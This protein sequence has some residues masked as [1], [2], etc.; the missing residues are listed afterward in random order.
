MPPEEPLTVL[1]GD[2]Q[3]SAFSPT[4]I[5]RKSQFSKMGYTDKLTDSPITAR[6]KHLYNRAWYIENQKLMKGEKANHP[7][8]DATNAMHERSQIGGIDIMGDVIHCADSAGPHNAPA[9]GAVQEMKRWEASFES[10]LSSYKLLQTD[11][12]TDLLAQAPLMDSDADLSI[13]GDA[14]LESFEELNGTPLAM[15]SQQLYPLIPLIS[16]SS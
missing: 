12:S 10:F 4:P 15:Q 9:V 5:L 16:S 11:I 1:R 8:L 14:V 13:L 2:L 7:L 6:S 3:R